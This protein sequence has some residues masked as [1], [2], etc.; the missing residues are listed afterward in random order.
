MFSRLPWSALLLVVGC[1]RDEQ[2][3]LPRPSLP[4]SSAAPIASHAPATQAPLI[5]EIPVRAGFARVERKADGRDEVSMIEDSGKDGS[6][7]VCIPPF[8]YDSVRAFFTAVREAILIGDAQEVAARISLPLQVNGSSPRFIDSREQFLREYSKIVTPGVIARVRE[9]DPGRVFCNWQ[10]S[11]LGNGVLW[12]DIRTE[13]RLG[14]VTINLPGT[15]NGLTTDLP[16]AQPVCIRDKQSPQLRYGIAV[17]GRAGLVQTGAPI[18][19]GTLNWVVEGL[20]CVSD[21]QSSESKVACGPTGKHG[22]PVDLVG[23]Q[24]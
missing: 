22:V 5:R 10:G 21:P 19:P 2:R 17:P 13:N 7:S 16:L 18:L 4:S 14:I 11:M 3:Q 20:G 24:Q 8:S 9:S 23:C 1:S 6:W 12:S 15:L